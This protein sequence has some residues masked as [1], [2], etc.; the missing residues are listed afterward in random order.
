MIVGPLKRLRKVANVGGVQVAIT[1]SSTG[2]LGAAML[3]VMTRV[4]MPA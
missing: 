3:V 4:D 1:S 2:G